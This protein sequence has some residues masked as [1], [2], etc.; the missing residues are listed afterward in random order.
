MSGLAALAHNRFLQLDKIAYAYRFVKLVVRPHVHERSNSHAGSKAAAVDDAEILHSH[1]IVKSGIDD[2][3]AGV[4]LT[5]LTDFR[6]PLEVHARMYDC[7]GANNDPLVDVRRCG[8]LNRHAGCHELFVLFL[9]HDSARF[10]QFGPAVDT[11]NLVRIL[12]QDRLDVEFPPAIGRN[13]I[14]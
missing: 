9:F 11:A 12:E 7:I 13:Q 6:P 2:A 1:A 8:I 3:D 4:N 5:R 14:R 10:C